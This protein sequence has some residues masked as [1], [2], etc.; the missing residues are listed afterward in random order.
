MRIGFIG[1]GRMGSRMAAN[2]AKAGFELSVYNRTQETAERFAGEYGSTVAPTPRALAESVDVI[3]TMLAHEAAI[4][5]CYT[6]LNG[7]IAGLDPTKVCIEMSTIGPAAVDRLVFLMRD[8]GADLVD[9]PVS[10]ATAAAEART[11][12]IMAGGDHDVVERV[13]PVLDAMG[14]TVLHIGESGTGAALKLSINSVI[15][16]INEAV[17]EALVMAE[18]AG[19]DRAVAYDAFTKSAIAA[20]VVVYRR[21]VFE[22]PGSV[23]VTFTIDLA[24]KDLG[25]ISELGFDVGAPLPQ[26][27]RN[28][29]IM[30]AASE[31][32]FGERDMGEV[33][34]YLRDTL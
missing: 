28:R 33:A 2:I 19:V 21:P 30:L 13:R 1:L 25:L 9:A 23:P 34:V 15:Y 24:L 11:L 27:E 26:A 3:I 7:V 16:G 5:D 4:E 29:E 20:P 6:G 14:Q 32:G 22:E 31:A 17:A 18:R 8:S 12:M 10:G